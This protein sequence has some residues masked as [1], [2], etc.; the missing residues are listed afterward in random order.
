MKESPLRNIPC[1]K[2][3]RVRIV[4]DEIERQGKKKRGKEEKGMSVILRRATD[5]NN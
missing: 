3:N 2:R 1:K 5:M 4:K